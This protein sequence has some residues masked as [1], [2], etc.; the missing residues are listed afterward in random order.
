MRKLP[1]LL[2]FTIL[3]L[4]GCTTSKA[5]QEV[6]EVVEVPPVAQLEP[7]PEQEEKTEPKPEPKPEPVVQEP[8][9]EK[10]LSLE[11]QEFL[12]STVALDGNEIVSIDT[13]AQDKKDILEI[14]DKLAVI[15]KNSDYGNWLKYVSP[16]SRTYW[17]NPRNLKEVEK[18]LPIKG[19]KI[20]SLNDYFKFIFVPARAGHQVDEIRYVSNTWVKAVQVQQDK[21]IVFYTFEKID[22]RWLL[23]LDTL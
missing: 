1:I 5:T 18:K 13:F 4:V 7:E 9:P 21:D 3:I 2:I 19:L 23:K 10:E 6:V 16:N 20:T 22:G 11:E 14:I 17:S 8:V 12:R 15:M